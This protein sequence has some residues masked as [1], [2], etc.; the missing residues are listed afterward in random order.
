MCTPMHTPMRKLMHKPMHKSMCTAVHQ[1]TCT[2]PHVQGRGHGVIT[3]LAAKGHS[4]HFGTALC[5]PS[6]HTHT[7]GCPWHRQ[8]LGLRP[9]AVRDLLVVVP[10]VPISAEL[11]LEGSDEGIPSPGP[12]HH[13]PCWGRCGICWHAAA[14]SGTSTGVVPT[15]VAV[16]MPRGTQHPPVRLV[17]CSRSSCRKGRW[18]G[19]PGTVSAANGHQQLP[20]RTGIPQPVGGQNCQSVALS[21]L[22]LLSAQPLPAEPG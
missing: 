2:H 19:R 9:A 7:C 1:H 4:V 6:P 22:R 15:V 14:C 13:H 20:P 18:E 12:L 8:H 21:Y 5:S 3:L 17:V 16:P 10:A 11:Q